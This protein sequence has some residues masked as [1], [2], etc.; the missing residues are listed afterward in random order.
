MP[1]RLARS[2]ITA[3]LGLGLLVGA[4]TGVTVG[5]AFSPGS[6]AHAA[7]STAQRYD[8][9][10]YGW[11]QS[12]PTQ[13]LAVFGDSLVGES[14]PMLQSLAA[15]RADPIAIHFVSGGAP[16]DVLP[17]YGTQMST[18]PVTRVA[19]AFVG[20]AVSACMVRRLGYRPPSTMRDI[21]KRNVVNVYHGDL[22]TMIR[23]NK[24]RG[25]VT[26]L[27]LPPVM[28]RGTYFNQIN[29]DLVSLYTAMSKNDPSWVRVN[30]MSRDL[31]TPGGTYRATALLGGETVK[32]RY[33]KDNVH[34]MAPAGTYL[35]ALGLLLPMIVD[36]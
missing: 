34:L 23:W 33:S 14:R 24:S 32:L 31:L 30:G 8:G 5:G 4:G 2:S 22:N 26:W 12:A 19:F 6:A 25:L 17:S 13:K 7:T 11:D 35:N 10:G 28:G 27:S 20:N 1:S 29:A 36:P 3:A 21:D 9:D 16:C 15:T 18:T